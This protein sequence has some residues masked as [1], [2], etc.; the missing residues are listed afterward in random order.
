VGNN[1]PDLLDTVAYDVEVVPL[2]V[3][4]QAGGCILHWVGVGYS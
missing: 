1:I 4:K 3:A 2:D